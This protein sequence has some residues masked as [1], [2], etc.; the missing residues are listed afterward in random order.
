MRRIFLIVATLL[1]WFFLTTSSFAEGLEDIHISDPLIQKSVDLYNAFK[2][3]SEK[4]KIVLRT[5][6]AVVQFADAVNLAYLRQ[7]KACYCLIKKLPHCEKT[8]SDFYDKYISMQGHIVEKE[9][10]CQELVNKVEQDVKEHLPEMRF[11]LSL[12][13][14]D[15]KSD[16]TAYL[17]L[18]GD[19]DIKRYST[20]R[21]IHPVLPSYSNRE[22]AP[23][24]TAEAKRV[25]QRIIDLRP[26]VCRNFYIRKN[27]ET[28]D[29]LKKYLKKES[30]DVTCDDI[31]SLTRVPI[32][33]ADD[34]RLRKVMN[35]LLSFTKDYLEEFRQAWLKYYLNDIKNAPLILFVRGPEATTQE[36]YDAIGRAVEN[37]KERAYRQPTM[38]AERFVEESW[39]VDWTKSLL[40]DHLPEENFDVEM[41]RL[42]KRGMNIS[43]TKNQGIMAV[44]IAGM[45]ACTYIPTGRAIAV[46]EGLLA[47]LVAG[48][49]LKS[50]PAIPCT[51]GLGV[52]TN[53][54]FVA[55]AFIRQN[56][57]I[58]KL[59]SAV[60]YENVNMDLSELLSAEGQVW[61]TTVLAPFIGNPVR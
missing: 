56:D 52:A 44:T 15:F 1:P 53:S 43:E 45:V 47:R 2:P 37:A 14:T 61:L 21:L 26:K 33:T 55:D 30:G 46:G 19:S 60:K 6:G 10:S 9:V 50:N 49:A 41:D 5:H 34:V 59:T 48:V 58:K 51:L 12:S 38:N 13:D 39:I 25:Q 23:Q 31:N 20:Y 54:Y 4:E 42:K 24:T 16:D 8:D 29:L 17:F 18:N 3:Y 40:R 11:G 36:I 35:S 28:K 27:E 7:L 22:I 32:K 57:V